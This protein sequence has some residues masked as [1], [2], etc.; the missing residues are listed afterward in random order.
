MNYTQV[1]DGLTGLEH[2]MGV[3]PLY[4]DVVELFKA[5]RVGIT[6]TLLVV[7][8][9]PAGQAYFDQSNRVWEHEKLL[10]FSRSED[11]RS[12]RRVT[13]YWDDDLYAPQMAAEMKRLFDE[14]V[15]INAGGHGQMLGLDMH[16]ELELF[17]Q[18]GFSPMEA[19]QV[20]T[21]NGAEYHGLDHEIGTIEAGKRA[22]LL[23][24][25]SNPLDDIRNTQDI[26]YVLRDGV[27][28]DGRDAARVYPGPREA[29]RFY[30]QR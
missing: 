18:G 7:Y 14:G 30:F 8:N 6:P 15:L 5:S 3:T 13:H 4:G 24:L 16:W 1:V 2:S 10:R 11:L 12:F 19:L 27:V 29:A 26:A 20:A 22:D 25:R 23:V 17:V 9:G 28:Y 21:R